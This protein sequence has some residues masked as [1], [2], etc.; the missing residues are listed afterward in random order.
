MK[1]LGPYHHYP[2][3]KVDNDLEVKTHTISQSVYIQ[4]ALELIEI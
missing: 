4:K 2:E 3:M 1:N